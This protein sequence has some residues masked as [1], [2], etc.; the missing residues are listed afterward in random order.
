[1]AKAFIKLT[2]ISKTFAGVKA[3]QHVD[4]VINE[5]ET[6]CLAGENGGGKSTLIKVI[7][8]FYTPDS[9]TIEING[10]V[11]KHL[12]PQQAINEGIQIIYQD[13]SIF[14]NLTVAENIALN[15][16]RLEGK[17]L[18]SWKTLREKAKRALQLVNVEM[19]L[20]A[21][22]GDLSVADRQLVAI[23][24]ALLQ[25]AK[26]LVMDEPTTA[27]TRKEVDSLFKVVRDLQ[28]K[29]ISILFVSHKL[30]EVFEIAEHLTILRNGLKVIEGPMNEFD[31]EKFI[32]YM[33]GRKIEDT[34]YPQPEV[35]G[36]PLMKA[37]RIGIKDLF[38]DVSFEL[39]PGEI[40]GITGLL[41]SGRSELARALF[42]LE[43]MT[44]GRLY[45]QG[46]EVQINSVTDAVRHGIGYVPED[47]LT[48]GLF[49]AHTVSKNII[50]ATIDSNLS[51][52]TRLLD[53]EKIDVHTYTWID[54]LRIKTPTGEIPVQALSG[55]N[56]QKVVL[57]KWLATNPKVLILNSPTV[58]V[59]I[60]SKTDIHA[61]ARQLA[62]EGMGIIVI[63]DDISEVL[64]NCNRVLI[65]KKGRIVEEH[66][67]D[68]LD[69]AILSHKLSES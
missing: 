57:A 67:C 39:Y 15:S 63:S 48:E 35:S 59:D 32:Y 25:D 52:A 60:G 56:Q 58:G 3:L 53:R 40:M 9:G 47:R 43:R 46:E 1:M 14:P 16:E 33:T 22:V 8:G 18:V 42:G 44:E 29:G 55:G 49:M 11:F 23:C 64:Q 68:A 69:D 38:K 65:M 12:T 37:E 30:E 24:R 66:Q 5:G 17:K 7:S 62:Q 4:M 54:E 41:G 26:L 45:I 19:D 2:D 21:R 50:S 20:D 10:K 36:T 34:H 61:Y 31:R 6:R 13:F 51:S 28:A 27:L